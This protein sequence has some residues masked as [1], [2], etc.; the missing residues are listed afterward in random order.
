MQAEAVFKAEKSDGTIDVKFTFDVT[1][2]DGKN[3]V[4]FEKLYYADTG[5]EAANHEDLGDKGQTVKVKA[6]S[7]LSSP[8]TGDDFNIAL[9]IA[10]MLAAGAAVTAVRIISRRKERRSKAKTK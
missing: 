8:K 9:L 1:G 5:I 7:P 3:L 6:D 10:L 4:V 2:L